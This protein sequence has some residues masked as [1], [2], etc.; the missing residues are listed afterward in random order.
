MSRRYDW[1]SQQ[2][3]LDHALEAAKYAQGKILED[4][5]VGC[6]WNCGV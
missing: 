3:M 4:V 2:Q 5:I 1:V 6:T